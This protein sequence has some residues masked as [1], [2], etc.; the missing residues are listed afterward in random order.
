MIKYATIKDLKN[1]IKDIPDDIPIYVSNECHTY[2]LES[3][4]MWYD[5]EYLDDEDE[6]EEDPY[7]GSVFIISRKF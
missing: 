5:K 3:T 4:G 7:Y 2:P 6:T 1:A